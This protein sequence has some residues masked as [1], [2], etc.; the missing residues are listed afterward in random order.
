MTPICT[1]LLLSAVS[2]AIL[3]GSCFLPRLGKICAWLAAVWLGAAIPIMFFS[4]VDMRH[5]L[6]FYL[7]S[8]AFGLV[9][10]FGGK[11]A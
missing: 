9:F 1:V 6:L 10:L 7:I 8:A 3:A 11:K 5:M 4:E 2:A